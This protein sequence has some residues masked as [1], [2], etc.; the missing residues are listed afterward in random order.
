MGKA[1]NDQLCAF[2]DVSPVKSSPPKVGEEQRRATRYMV[3]WRAAISVDRQNFYYGRLR[4]ISP[5][6]AAILND[7]NIKPGTHVTLKIYIPTIDKPCEPKVLIVRGVTVY[8]VYDAERLCFRAG[9]SFVKS[10]QASECV[11]LEERLK[12]P[13]IAEK[14]HVC[15]RS[16]DRAI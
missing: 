10:G 12:N 11:Y 9:I 2:S 6:G 4:D 13:A 1:E 7:L 15:R 3:S 5:H 14:D 16:T 8:T